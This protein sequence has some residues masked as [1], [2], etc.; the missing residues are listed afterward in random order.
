MIR[1]KWF[2]AG[3]AVEVGLLLAGVGAVVYLGYRWIY[4]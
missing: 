2:P 1:P 4:G 3:N